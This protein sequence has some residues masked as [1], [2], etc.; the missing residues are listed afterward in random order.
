MSKIESVVR[1]TL[2][3]DVSTRTVGTRNSTMWEVYTED[4]TKWVT[5]L[6]GVG[7]KAMALKGQKAH[8]KVAIEQKDQYTNYVLTDVKA[9]NGGVVEAAANAAAAQIDYTTY[10]S[11]EDE[12]EKRK[13]LSI[14]RQVAAK[15]AAAIQEPGDGSVTFWQNVQ[16]LVTYFETG[17]T[18][19]TQ[20]K[21][22][23]TANTATVTSHS[24]YQDGGSDAPQPDDDIPF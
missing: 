1:D 8:L 7:N 19:L 22:T 4:G 11:G 16:H 21:D 18:P 14:H 13:N 20:A 23:E 3:T 17:N 24:Y 6:A 5:F 9:A 12:K 10:R 2:I 15:V